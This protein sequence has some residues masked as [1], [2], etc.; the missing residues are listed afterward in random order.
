MKILEKDIG[1]YF[2]NFI[3]RENFVSMSRQYDMKKLK[4]Y[5]KKKNEYIKV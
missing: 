4:S 5:R 2:H 3:F 1:K